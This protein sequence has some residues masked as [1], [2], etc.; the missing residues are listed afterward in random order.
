VIPVGVDHYMYFVFDDAPEEVIE[1]LEETFRVMVDSPKTDYS[2]RVVNYLKRKG[3][4]KKNVQL[5]HEGVVFLQEPLRV[6]DGRTIEDADFRL[7]EVSG[8][9]VLELHPNPRNWWPNVRDVDLFKF[10]GK[11]LKEG[12]LLI[13]G[14]RDD[15]NLEEIGFGVNSRYLLIQ[16]LVDIAREGIVRKIPSALTMVH[17]GYV[18]LGEGLYEVPIPWRPNK[19][20]FLF[21]TELMNYTVLW[22]LGS[23]DFNDPENVYESL[24]ESWELANDVTMPIMLPLETVRRVR[25]EGLERFVKR[26]F[27]AHVSG[28]YESSP[29]EEIPRD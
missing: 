29:C 12:A 24:C 7:Y 5:T 23:V 26:V 15:I 25:R 17:K 22:F 28:D 20:G 2:N 4:L 14:Y 18:R 11:F 8:Y 27:N 1:F 9:S 10:L 13:S 21:I 16:W 6:G 3:V 19:K